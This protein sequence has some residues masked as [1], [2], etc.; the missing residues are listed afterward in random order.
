MTPTVPSCSGALLYVWDLHPEEKF[1]PA[2]AILSLQVCKDVTRRR[3]LGYTVWWMGG[4][5]V[6]INCVVIKGKPVC[7]MWS[8]RDPSLQK[9]GVDNIFKN[10]DRSIDNKTL[11]DTFS[12][13]GSILSCNLVCDEN[14]S[15]GYGFVHF[16][17]QE[18]AEQAIEKMNEL[19]LND[20]KV[21]TGQFTAPKEEAELRA[22]AKE[23]TNAFIK[24]F[25]ED[26]DGEHLKD[27]FGKFRPALVKARTDESGK[28]KGFGYVSFDRQKPVHEMNVGNKFMLVELREKVEWQTEL[29]CRFERGSKKI[30]RYQGVN[31]HVKNLD[32][33]IDDE[34]PRKELSPGTI[35]SAEVMMERWLPQRP[36]EASKAF[37]E[38]N[39]K[40]VAAKPLYVALGQLKEERQAHLSKYMQRMASVR[41]MLNPVVNPYQQ[42]PPSGYF[43]AAI[44]QP[45]NHAAYYPLSQIAQLTPSDARPNP[46]QNVPGTTCTAGPRPPFTTVRPDS[47]QVPQVTS[48]QRV[49]TSTQAMGPCPAA[50]AATPAVCTIPQYKHAAGVHNA[51]EHLNTQPQV[52]T[53]P[54][55]HIQSQEHLTASMLASVP[56]SQKQ[57]LGE[58]VPP[59]IQAMHPT[60]AGEITGILLETDNSELLHMLES[61][62]SLRS[63]ADE[64]VAVLQAHQAKEAAQKSVNCATGVLTV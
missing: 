43:M 40:T 61:P 21:F 2:G 3:S 4:A 9:I 63:K 26:M 36:E 11:Y 8:Q 58:R 31:L 19:L 52:I 41:G 55:V 13:A 1:S 37:T 57:T 47:S 15:K 34:R 17:T 6:T 59:F 39:S 25:R 46:F 56:P 49:S 20:G 42:A 12:A 60:L 18:A 44:P 7:I 24:N 30:T 32:D 51:Q 45:Q 22:R 53:Q 5:L 10:L 35:T 14:D 54:A 62:A 29:K 48:T 16:E 28:P 64:A 23:F 27:L 38:M 50:A 33:G